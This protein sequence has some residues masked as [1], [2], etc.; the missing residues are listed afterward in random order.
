MHGYNLGFISDKDLFEHVESTVK[1]YR[2]SINFS[3]FKKNMID[4]IKLTFDSKVYCMSVEDLV[5]SE[6]VRQLDKSNNNH[7]GYFH[8]NIFRYIASGWVV[9]EK[10]F[11][12][13]NEKEKIFVEIKNKHNTM[14]SNSSQKLFIN[15]Q[16]KLIEDREATCMLV[17]V[18]A[19][20]SQNIPWKISLNG[21]QVY[22]E[23]IRRVSIDKFYEIV[24]GDASAFKKLCIVLPKVIGDVVNTI[25]LRHIE[26]KV[27]DELNA[28][29]G[30]LLQ[31]FYLLSFKKY[32]GFDAFDIVE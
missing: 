7:I 25:Q 32:E 21:T 28:I 20:D 8:Q 19:K 22:N 27:I 1:Q 24:T 31:S 3:E 9:P 2:F 15:M 23:N 29:S 16:N 17:E 10:G 14:N 30:N 26:K 11:D 18:I 6:I 12:V 4:P 5:E 13:V